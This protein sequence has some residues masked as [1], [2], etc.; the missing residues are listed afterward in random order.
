MKSVLK[1]FST[2]VLSELRSAESWVRV[3]LI[4]LLLAGWL[5]LSFF[6]SKGGSS[7]W[8]LHILLLLLLLLFFLSFLGWGGGARYSC[9]L[10]IWSLVRLGYRVTFNA[11]KILA[12]LDFW[13]LFFVFCCVPMKILC[14]FSGIL[15]KCHILFPCGWIQFSLQWCAAALELGVHT[16]VILFWVE[17][18]TGEAV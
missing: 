4:F 14:P 16:W 11:L 17:I 1:I 3:L 7:I 12:K 15:W 6:W 10:G 18:S 13:P 2:I 8:D 9:K 5:L